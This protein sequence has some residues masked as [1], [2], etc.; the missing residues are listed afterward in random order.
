MVVNITVCV[1]CSP[2]PY[3]ELL[4]W[5]YSVE[6]N[7]QCKYGWLPIATGASQSQH[8]YSNLHSSQWSSVTDLRYAEQEL[9]HRRCLVTD[10][11]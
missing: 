6:G 7:T 9:Q 4:P 8:A 1:P 3:E 2:P 11:S 10:S 5:H